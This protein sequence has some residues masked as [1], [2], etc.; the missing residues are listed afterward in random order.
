MPTIQIRDIPE[1][2]YETIRHRAR[3]EGKSIQSY[4]HDQV[5]ELAGHRTKAEV[6][7]ALEETLR[8]DSIT[9]VTA[10]DVVADL[11]ADRR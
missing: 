7:A 11:A 8:H 3:N 9:M 4:M 2:A 10:N 1:T 6:L 5:I